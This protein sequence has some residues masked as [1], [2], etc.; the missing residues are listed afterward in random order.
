MKRRNISDIETHE[1]NPFMQSTGD[2]MAGLLF[3]FILLLMGTLVQVQEKAKEDKKIATAYDRIKNDLSRDLA[4]EFKNELKIWN[5]E[6]D[7]ST[8]SIRFKEPDVLFDKNKDSIKT[9]FK[10][11]LDEF[12]P[13]YI[14]ILSRQ[15]YKDN[16]EEIRI[17]GHTDSDGG[18][19]HNVALSQRRTIKV[20]E[21]CHEITPESYKTWIEKHLT[22][23][24]LAYSK[25]ITM[26][27]FGYSVEDKEASRRV[28]FR[29]RTNAEKLLE[30]IAKKRQ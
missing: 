13:K 1:E 28:E 19:L 9:E 10:K 21:Y 29:V 17:E 16:I 26:E 11:I 14:R 25:P 20:L 18:Y 3:I 5:A 6:L 7:K 23:N 4:N 15:Q 27:L 2:L 8:L 12:F 30:K 24:G 22:A